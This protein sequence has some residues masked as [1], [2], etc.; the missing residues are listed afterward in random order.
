[1]QNERVQRVLAIVLI[2]AAISA[3]YRNAFNGVFLLDDGRTI[4]EVAAGG[5]FSDLGRPLISMTFALDL[6]LFGEKPAGYH[7]IN[8]LVHCAAALLLFGW[9]RRAL[10][11][12]RF[13]EEFESVATAIAFSIS[14]I[15]ALHPLQTESVTYIVQRAESLMG[16]FYLLTLYAFARSVP[17]AGCHLLNDKVARWRA[18]ALGACLLGMATKEAMVTAPLV[19]ML[20]DCTF[21][22]GGIAAAWRQRRGFY[23]ALASTWLL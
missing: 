16:L 2:V 11:L 3:A 17:P 6:A 9:V 7:A 14:L 23:L 18:L 20:Y 19:V 13:R 8:I 12:P 10:L 4:R 22:A 15:W 21:L 5:P 1:M